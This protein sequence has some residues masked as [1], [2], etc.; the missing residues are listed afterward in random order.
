[1]TRCHASMNKPGLWSIDG[2]SFEIVQSGEK[3]KRPQTMDHTC[4]GIASHFKK[5]ITHNIIKTRHLASLLLTTRASCF[6]HYPVLSGDYHFW[7][8]NKREG[9]TGILGLTSINGRYEDNGALLIT[10]QWLTKVGNL[11]DNWSI[12]LPVTYFY[13]SCPTN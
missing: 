7:L 10:F 1:M 6:Y 13:A 12:F 4:I 9:K 3:K 5:H 11:G 8:A 2:I